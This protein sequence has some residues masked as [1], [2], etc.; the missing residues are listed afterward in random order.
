MGLTESTSSTRGEQIGSEDEDTQKRAAI[1]PIQTNNHQKQELS[2]QENSHRP[3]E[4]ANPTEPIISTETPELAEEIEF[5]QEASLPPTAANASSESETP[6]AEKPRETNENK[7]E[8]PWQSPAPSRKNIIPSR[9]TVF[10]Q[11]AHSQHIVKKSAFSAEN[12]QTNFFGSDEA[13]ERSKGAERDQEKLDLSEQATS[14]LPLPP[15]SMPD[16]PPAE[17]T[18]RTKHKLQNNE[19][20]MPEIA[21]SNRHRSSPLNEQEP[22]AR[23]ASAPMEESG[24]SDEIDTQILPTPAISSAQS[25]LP[26]TPLPVVQPTNLE[27]RRDTQLTRGKASLLTL[28]LIIVVI[29][30]TIAGFG[31]FFGPQGW[32]SVFNSS[33][34]SSGNL[35]DQIRKQLKQTP[36]PGATVQTTPAPLTPEQIVNALVSQMTLEQKLG[37]MMIV[38]FYGQTYTPQLDAMI[39]Q[40]HIGGVLFFQFNI[41]SKAQL[42]SL[43]TEMQQ[44]ADL[45][46]IVSVDQEGGTVDRFVNLDGAQ[47]SAESIGLTGDPN[48]AYKQ[49]V[50]DAKNLASYGFNLNLAPVVDVHNVYNEQLYLRTYGDNPATVTQMAGA[51]L[52]GLQK[53]GKVMGTLKH[54]PGLGDVGDDPHTRPPD[55]T[56]SLQDL[57]SID[58]APY[59]NLIN[60]GNVYAVMVT[61]EYVQ[62][63]DNKEPSSLSPQVIGI[64]RNQLHFNGVIITDGLTMQSITNYYTPGQAA[65]KAIEAGDDI[66]M[67]A[68]SPNS[69]AAMINGIKQAMSTG[70]ITEERIN[71]S[72][73]RILLFKYQMGLLQIHS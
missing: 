21:N 32:G 62:A 47:P 59:R 28:F 8:I 42:K 51:Y 61:H 65:A 54:F 50:Q 53:S 56:R 33:T 26:T 25:E 18:A 16:N 60:Q 49:G 2:L 39:R 63:L 29:N 10:E 22:L 3:G 48:N 30:A 4:Q 66:L 7:P 43:T 15:R 70:A 71:E 57:N 14:A 45:P 27:K 31:Q 73:R 34:N 5:S 23:R 68:E 19:E 24:R 13:L 46:L 35:L 6:P 41:G 72:V 1:S 40:Y 11:N 12:Q 55:L 36:T 67:G 17:Q 44:S 38:Q 9:R 52:E 69:V 37:Q 64:L 58:W 20:K